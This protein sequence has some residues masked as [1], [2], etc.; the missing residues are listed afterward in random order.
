M[1]CDG[2]GVAR[3]DVINGPFDELVSKL[4]KESDRIRHGVPGELARSG[5]IVTTTIRAEISAATGGS[6][7]LRGVSWRKGGTKVGAGWKQQ[8]SSLVTV[9]ARGPLHLLERDT[10]RHLAPKDRRKTRGKRKWVRVAPGI[11][12]HGPIMVGGSRGKHPFKKGADRA[13]P[14]V[15]KSNALWL[16]KTLGETF[17]H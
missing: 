17:H 12:R 15:Q 3:D 16:T 4:N 9:D 2:C 14:L 10:K 8:T 5:Q 7:K 11:Y 1:A 6:G 13:L